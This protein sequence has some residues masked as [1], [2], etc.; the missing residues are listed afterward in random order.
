MQLALAY[1]KSLALALMT[2]ILSSVHKSKLHMRSCAQKGRICQ[3]LQELQVKGPLPNFDLDQ[4]SK[5]SRFTCHP[6]H[7]VIIAIFIA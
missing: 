1:L 5:S 3:F 4:R 2:L 6:A 7:L